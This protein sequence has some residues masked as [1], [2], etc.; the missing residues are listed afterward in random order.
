MNNSTINKDCQDKIKI[1]LFKDTIKNKFPTEIKEIYFHELYDIFKNIKKGNKDGD[2]IVNGECIGSRAN[3]NIKNARLIPF[4]ADYGLENTPC[5]DIKTT[6]LILDQL[7]YKYV[8]YSSFSN[9][10]SE[11]RY[12]IFFICDKNVQPDNLKNIYPNIITKLHN[13]GLLFQPNSESTT[14]SQGWYLPRYQNETQK[15]IFECYMGG[16]K[17]IQFD[18]FTKTKENINKYI[19][20]DS[21][22]ILNFDGMPNC[23]KFLSTNILEQTGYRNFNTIS[24]ILCSY[25]I[26]KNWTCDKAIDTFSNFIQ[27][28]QYSNSLTNEDLRLNNFIN[29]FNSMQEFNYQFSCGYMKSLKLP[30]YAYECKKCQL[31]NIDALWDFESACTAIEK[32]ECDDFEIPELIEDIVA[33]KDFDS[34]KTNILNRKIKAKFKIGIG[35]LKE[36]ENKNKEL[37]HIQICNKYISEKFNNQNIICCDDKIWKYNEG[38]YKS[39]ELDKME[40]NIANSYNYNACSRANDYKSIAN[41]VYKTLKN[42][43]YF[44]NTEYKF[45][46]NNYVI[47]YDNYENKLKLEKHNPNNKLKNKLNYDLTLSKKYDYATSPLFAQYLQDSFG[48]DQNQINLLQEICGSILIGIGYKLQKIFLLYG[49]GQNGKSLILKVLDSI[50]N[51]QYKSNIP[52]HLLCDEKY[53]INIKNKIVNFCGDIDKNKGTDAKLKEISGAD[54]KITGRALYKN[55]DSFLPKSTIIGCCNELPKTNDYTEGFFRRWQIIYYRYYITKPD[56]NL[57]NKIIDKESKQFIEWALHGVKRLINNDFKLTH[58]EENNTIIE[59]WKNNENSVDNY[60]NDCLITDI[61]NIVNRTAIY[62]HYRKYCEKHKLDAI[63][64][65]YFYKKLNNYYEQKKIKGNRCFTGVK[66]I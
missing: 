40:I 44:D 58:T 6:K 64:N 13:N 38:I 14:L 53:A 60:I 41:L 32:F 39:Y 23:I 15:D 42:E 30:G 20:I 48:D 16:S 59:N 45:A 37:N 25:A 31:N 63:N 34:V 18:K 52:L 12:R 33:N 24:M 56:V 21:E 61:N 9:S 2:Y 5:P 11:P 66:Y 47:Y 27:E 49:N 26:S 35:A 7:D 3:I 4:D 62:N 1:T 57:A 54:I 17:Y 43:K 36:Y 55:V 28:Y 29:R 19:Y 8:L 46:T 50:I 10:L 51:S 65:N 22:N